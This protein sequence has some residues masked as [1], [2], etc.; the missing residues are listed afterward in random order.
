MVEVK[1]KAKPSRSNINA[2]QKHIHSR[3]SYLYQAATYLT[4]TLSNQY[5]VQ[6]G[7]TTITQ[8]LAVT[9]VG[10]LQEGVAEH[11]PPNQNANAVIADEKL[12]IAQE[13]TSI[14]HSTAV[15]LPCRLLSHAR[16]ISMKSQMRLTST[17]KHSICK[18]C[19]ILLV[20]G[21]TS[22]TRLEN[23]SRGGKKPWA[24]VLVVTC[25]VCNTAK[26]FPVGAKRQPKCSERS[27]RLQHQ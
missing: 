1:A 7:S 24:D 27:N 22:T 15:G 3:M 20:P 5:E 16:S 23:R 14:R 11:G 13:L 21:S 26:R 25:T 17:M 6:T 10:D 8:C 2:P 9:N 19:D 18:R 12:D 4:Q